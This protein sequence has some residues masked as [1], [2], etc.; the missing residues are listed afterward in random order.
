MA[1]KT[2]EI[3]TTGD[4]EDAEEQAIP[5]SLRILLRIL[6]FLRGGDLSDFSFAACSKDQ[7]RTTPALPSSEL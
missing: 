1:G 3:F 2:I 5:L 4:T 7:E 6:R